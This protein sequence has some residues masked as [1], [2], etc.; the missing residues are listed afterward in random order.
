MVIEEFGPYP[1]PCPIQEAHGQGI[2]CMQEV[3]IGE[4]RAQT[5]VRDVLH[6]GRALDVCVPT[7]TEGGGRHA[8]YAGKSS[9]VGGRR[10]PRQGMFGSMEGETGMSGTRAAG[11]LKLAYPSKS[12]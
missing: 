12:E 2:M 4:R 7:E 6:G 3:R 1:D 11:L 5:V 8:L 10:G 9:G